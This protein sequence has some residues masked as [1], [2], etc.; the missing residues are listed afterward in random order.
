MDAA[1]TVDPNWVIDRARPPAE[2]ILDTKY[3]KADLPA[4][5]EDNCS[6]LTPLQ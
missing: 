1:A 3:V 5:V 6:H 4:I 2:K